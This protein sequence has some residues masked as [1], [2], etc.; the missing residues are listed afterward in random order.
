MDSG[1]ARACR[2]SSSCLPV[3]SLSR[4]QLRLLT[5]SSLNTMARLSLSKHS[6]FIFHNC[7]PFRQN[8]L[9]RTPPRAATALPLPCLP[10]RSFS[11]R[12]PLLSDHQS[13]HKLWYTETLPALVPVFLLGSAVYLACS[14]FC[15]RLSP[16]LRI[17]KCFQM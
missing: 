15:F 3:L 17:K 13:R 16:C 7:S 10:D 9:L 2:L 1:V 5:R 14:L 6:H 8:I 4:W 11:I 12:H